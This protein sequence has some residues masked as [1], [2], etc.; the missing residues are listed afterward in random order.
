MQATEALVNFILEARFEKMPPQGI[1]TAE[2]SMLDCLGC[3]L[4][5]AAQPTGKI[6][7][8]YVRETEA[9][10]I[11]TVIGQGFKTSLP[12][13]ALANGTAGH[14]DDYDDVNSVIFGHPSVALLPAI[15][16]TAEQVK[17]SGKEIIEAYIVGFEV[18]ARLGLALNPAHYAKGWH[19]TSTLGTPGAAAASAK[20]LKLNEQQIRM[21]LAI[22]ASQASG[23]RQNFGTMTKPFH[24]GNAA[25]S[26]VEAALLA[27]NGFTGDPN[28]IEAPLGFCNVFA[29]D[30]PCELGKITEGL[31]KEFEIVKSGIS[32]KP[33]P[34]CHETHPAIESILDLARKYNFGPPEVE[35]IECI[36]NETTNNILH[37]LEPKT[38]LEGKFSAEHCLARALLDGKVE[39]ADF[40]AE[41]VNQPE[42]KEIIK[43]VHRRIDTSMPPHCTCL[44]VRLKDGRQVNQRVEKTK[45]MPE[46]PLTFEEL[47]AKYRDCARFTLSPDKVKR[48]LELMGNLEDVKEVSELMSAVIGK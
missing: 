28:I 46:M 14:A 39:L 45:G 38:P 40:T 21:A 13:A 32:I 7:S 10:P 26:G 16:A 1:K 30:K 24:P 33:Y 18:T 29:G 41:R 43:K 4:L 44:D 8:E 27:Q 6:I 5:G 12:L 11:A 42:I 34:C 37:H 17:A 48:S 22:A 47:A 23:L 2:E 36:F 31:G 20:L 9:R 3:I 15:L 25:R 19:S 35:S